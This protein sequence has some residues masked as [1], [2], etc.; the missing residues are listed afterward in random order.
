MQPRPLS[1]TRP[2]CIVSRLRYAST[3]AKP[4]WL[5]ETSY[6]GEHGAT[7]AQQRYFSWGSALS[8]IGGSTLGFSPFR[9]F[10]TSADGSTGTP[11]GDRRRHQRPHRAEW[12]VGAGRERFGRRL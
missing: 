8:A 12:G 4:A 3:P 5:V 9:G 2:T 1:H 6:R 7:R 11:S 10:A